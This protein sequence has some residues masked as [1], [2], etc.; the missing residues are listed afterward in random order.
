MVEAKTTTLTVDKG[1]SNEHKIYAT[2][3]EEIYSKPKLK[4]INIPRPKSEW[5]SGARKT[6]ILDLLQV[7]SRFSI[8]GW[9][10]WSDRTKLRNIVS[11]QGGIFTLEYDGTDYSMAV[12]KYVLK[13]EAKKENNEA[14]VKFI[15]YVGENL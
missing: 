11:Q 8:D 14:E 12:E 1:G 3:V 15:A 13:N 4:K 7:E 9:I 2:V 6:K 10:D 5:G